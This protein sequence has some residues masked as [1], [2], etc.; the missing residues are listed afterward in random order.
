[1]ADVQRIHDHAGAD[2]QVA[3]L[4]DEDEVAGFRRA[5]IAIQHQRLGDLDLAAGDAVEPQGVGGTARHGVD[6]DLVDDADDTPRHDASAGLDLVLMAQHQRRLVHPHHVGGECRARL[7]VAVRRDEGIATGDVDLVVQRQRH[8]L[9]RIGHVQV[10]I[11]GHDARH[12]RTLAGGLDPNLAPHL[13]GTGRQRAAVTPEVE[14]GSIDVLH[15]EAQLVQVLHRH[16][17]D[18]LELGQQRRPV[19]PAHIATGI[20]DVV[21]VQRRYRQE[22]HVGHVQPVGEVAV[23]G[24]DLLEPG[25]GVVDQVH[26]VDCDHEVTN[27]EQIADETV[28][29][30]LQLHA[31]AR[32]DQDHRQ[33]GGGSAGGH[34]AGVL[35][36]SRGI[37][38]NELALVGGEK[39]IG[40]IDG[41]ALLPLRL[42]AI[43]QQRQIDLAAH[44]AP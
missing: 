31:V 10:A 39:P 12:G 7:D 6:V 38:D 24:N 42:Q 29:P 3:Q 33:A 19:E 8:R 4:V 9:P 28:P 23:I 2:R 25:L 5:L 26:L 11:V 15:R 18:Q 21:A 43:D 35:L 34:V 1:M 44:A 40:D 16:D 36:V 27:A 37:G 20:D 22:A 41:D 17:L 30:G 13:D 32:I 14:I